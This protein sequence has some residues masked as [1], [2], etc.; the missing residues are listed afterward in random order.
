MNIQFLKVVTAMNQQWIDV[1][2]SDEKWVVVYA[3]TIQILDSDAFHSII[4]KIGPLMDIG[5]DFG[6]KSYI[7]GNVKAR[8]LKN[9]L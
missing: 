9:I 7:F 4:K 2:G 3:I 8:T 6:N 5:E 1:I